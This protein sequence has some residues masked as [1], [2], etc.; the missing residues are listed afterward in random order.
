MKSIMKFNNDSF[1]TR[2]VRIALAI[3]SGKVMTYG[4]IA[5][6]AGGS[7]QS[8]RS[9]SGI[10]GKAYMRGEKKIPFHR[11]VYSGGT[12]WLSPEYEA[13]RR[14]LYKKEGIVLNKKGKIENFRDVLMEF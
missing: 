7:G 4:M 13:E 11:I 10:L 3:P 1:S 9:V 5:R 14:R 2:V 6:A 12:V 8:A